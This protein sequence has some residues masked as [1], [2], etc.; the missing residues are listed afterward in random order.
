MNEVEKMYKLANVQ[1]K[2]Y[3]NRDS[4]ACMS[5]CPEW[6][7]RQSCW[8]HKSVIPPFTAEKQVEIIKLIL[9]STWWMN[10]K[11]LQFS[12]DFGNGLAEL[13]NDI[14]SIVYAA[15]QTSTSSEPSIMVLYFWG[16]R[17]ALF[18]KI[19]TH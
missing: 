1:E 2:E 15:I 18:Y 17:Q 11:R 7:N 8:K 10:L 12:Q 16:Y 9:F 6:K 13:V 19:F 3:C 14:K 4:D 5:C